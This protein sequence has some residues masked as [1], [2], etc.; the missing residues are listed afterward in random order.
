MG[1]E[2]SFDF[3]TPSTSLKCLLATMRSPIH[4]ASCSKTTQTLR[5]QK[6]QHQSMQYKKLDNKPHECKRASC[7]QLAIRESVSSIMCEFIFCLSPRGTKRNDQMVIAK[8]LLL[9]TLEQPLLLCLA[10]SEVAFP[11]CLFIV[12]AVVLQRRSHLQTNTTQ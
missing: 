8:K 4:F 11:C 9:M 1:N 3:W 10:S 2:L 5:E 12:F 6:Q 7:P